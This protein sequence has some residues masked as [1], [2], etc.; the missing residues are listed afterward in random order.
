MAVKSEE[1]DSDQVYCEQDFWMYEMSS[2][3]DN[4]LVPSPRPSINAVFK[5]LVY[6]IPAAEFSSH[7]E[8]LAETLSEILVKFYPLA[9]RLT[10]NPLD[11]GIYILCN[12][13]GVDFI[14][15]M[16]EDLSIAD[17][18]TTEVTTAVEELFALKGA[19]NFEGHRLP[20]LVVQ[21]T[22]LKDGISVCCTLNHAIADGTSLWNFLNSWSN[23]CRTNGN[24]IP[25]N[26][27]YDRSLLEPPGSVVRL[28]LDLDGHV[29]RFCPPSLRVKLFHFSAHT[30]SRLKERANQDSSFTISSFQA[31]C[32]HVWRA[33]AVTRARRLCPDEHTIF[34]LSVNCRPRLLP[35]VPSSYF[36]NGHMDGVIRERI[37]KW[38]EE[39]VVYRLE[40]F[41]KNCV[42]MGSSP[43]FEMYENDF[44]WGRPV[45]ARGGAFNRLDGKI[46]AYPG[47]EG[48]GSVELEVCLNPTVMSALESDGDFIRE[49]SFSKLFY[50]MKRE[51]HETGDD[52]EVLIQFA[53]DHSDFISASEMKLLLVD[54][55]VVAAVTAV[56]HFPSIYL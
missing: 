7:V 24:K 19:L 12:D 9:G 36:G 3:S 28:G 55:A 15:A 42:L 38:G 41:Q 26:P 13:S 2:S 10:T 48:G 21:V 27:V 4:G 14:E 11:G 6:Q 40:E 50:L 1:D 39:A 51:I 46:S 32:A 25:V 35:A 56:F 49:L 23:L 16:A 33:G 45:A 37:G 34:R 52:E 22:Q 31:L 54:V 5:G 18:T 30:M 8:R 53:K 29:Q 17:L 43:R 20:L 47:R 44:G